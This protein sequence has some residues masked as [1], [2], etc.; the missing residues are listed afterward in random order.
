MDRRLLQLVD[1]AVARLIV[2]HDPLPRPRWVPPLLHTLVDLLHFGD[3]LAH[4]LAFDCI[5]LGVL[6]RDLLGRVYLSRR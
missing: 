3:K 1:F 2:D 4:G 6:R 5:K